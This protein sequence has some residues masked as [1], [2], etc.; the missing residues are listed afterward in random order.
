M[1]VLEISWTPIT[2]ASH[3]RVFCRMRLTEHLRGRKLVQ[4]IGSS[5][6]IVV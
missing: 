4:T 2:R 3:T 6:H 5:Q 1:T